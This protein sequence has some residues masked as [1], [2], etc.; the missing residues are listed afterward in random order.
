MVGH[1]SFMPAIFREKPFEQADSRGLPVLLKYLAAWVIPLGLLTILAMPAAANHI[2]RPAMVTPTCDNYTI[3]VKA[4]NLTPNRDYTITYSITVMPSSGTPM[5]ISNSIPF[6][7]PNSRTFSTRITQPLG[8]L[9]GTN[10]F[11][12]SATLIGFNTV[13]IKFTPSSLTCPPPTM[14]T[15]DARRSAPQN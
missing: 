13:P 14:S 5:T 15:G 8:P 7:T 9:T 6:T 10:S 4:V 2:Q 12:G 1:N 3:C 11:S